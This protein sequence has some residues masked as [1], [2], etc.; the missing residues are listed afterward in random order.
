VSEVRPDLADLLGSA[1]LDTRPST[2]TPGDALDLVARTAEA[3]AITGRLLHQAVGSARSSGHSWAAIGDA[4]GMSRQAAQKRF[5]SS[6]E[7]PIASA[8]ERTLGPV[9]AFDEMAELA[10]AGA[11]GWHTVGAGLLSHRMVRTD[12]RWEHRR[13]AWVKA[14]SHYE[15]DGWQIG[16]K[17]FPW[18]YLVR[19]TGLPVG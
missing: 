18:L 4:L 11:L 9:T 2:S 14:P 5:G 16:C 17:A 6:A 15:T 19:D 3:E 13:V 12:T 10:A 8:E 1:I 7:G